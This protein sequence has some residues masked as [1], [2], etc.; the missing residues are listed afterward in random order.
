MNIF[1][2]ILIGIFAISCDTAEFIRRKR[3]TMLKAFNSLQI[4][5]LFAASPYLIGW[6]ANASFPAH[7]AAF[8]LSIIGYGVLFILMCMAVFTAIEREL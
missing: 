5:A 6:L 7:T 3:R 1:E 8:W 4:T 2:C